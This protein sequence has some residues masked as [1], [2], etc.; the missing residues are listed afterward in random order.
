MTARQSSMSDSS[1][2]SAVFPAPANLASSLSRPL[3]TLGATAYT[4]SSDSF[5]DVFIDLSDGLTRP[6][7]TLT[8]RLRKGRTLNITAFDRSRFEISPANFKQEA[9]QVRANLP[10][11][12]VTSELIRLAGYF[13]FAA[14]LTDFWTMHTPRGAKFPTYTFSWPTG[15]QHVTLSGGIC[16]QLHDHKNPNNSIFIIIRPSAARAF[17]QPTF[18]LI[19]GAA[20]IGVI[21]S[22]W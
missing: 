22:L 14:P 10:M 8:V 4:L 11:V 15:G 7:E 2:F 20:L 12:C 16:V 13:I 17:A 1:S 19:A 21:R 3:A 6:R 18:A 5:N 9:Y